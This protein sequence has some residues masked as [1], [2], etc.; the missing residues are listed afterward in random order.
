MPRST[1]SSPLPWKPIVITV[2]GICL[3]AVAFILIKPLLS[4]QQGT[5]LESLPATEFANNATGYR[6][7]NYSVKG[8]VTQRVRWT[9][10]GEIIWLTTSPENQAIPVM[11]PANLSESNI[12]RG[13]NYLFEVQID[14]QGIPV[15]QSIME[16]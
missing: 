14:Q 12:D 1:S 16:L 3:L 11:I 7:N 6:G 8:E 5:Q 15:A 4:S 9:R 10:A 13:R 2:G